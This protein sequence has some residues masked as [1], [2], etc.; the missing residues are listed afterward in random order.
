MKYY[1]AL[2]KELLGSVRAKYQSIPITVVKRH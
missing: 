2:C 1:L